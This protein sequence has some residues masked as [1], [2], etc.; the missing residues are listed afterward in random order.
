MRVFV[1]GASGY[2]GYHV[3]KAFRSKGH[4]VYGL[5]RSQEC[6]DR[7]SVGE[8]WPILGDMS[9]PN[10]YIKTLDE[11]EVVVHCASDHS[12]KG[13]ELDLK[14]IDTVLGSFSKSTL[15]KAFIYTS[16][17]WVYGSTGNKVV[18]EASKLNPID[19][20]KWRPIHEEKI[21][22][23]TSPTLR[24]VILR[25][26]CVYG[27]AEGLATVFFTATANGSINII[28][29]GANRWPMV[30]VQDLAYA[31]VATTEK[32]L[33]HVILNVTNDTSLSVKEIAEAIARSAGMPGKISSITPDQAKDMY[34]PLVQ[35][36]MIDQQVNN[37]RIKRLLGW[38]IHHESFINEMDIYYNAWKAKDENV[39]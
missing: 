15:P 22:K 36:L 18:D 3:A 6:A 1:T 33:S 10:S 29:D 13:I 21:L 7:L 16:G 26:G 9:N 2:I 39:F 24:T 14:T 4:T 30:H 12:E 32:E 5:V 34:G 35:G 8:I 17:V 37:A 38:Q 11:V 25:P 23:A 31:Y 28:G 19:L 27:G 20:V